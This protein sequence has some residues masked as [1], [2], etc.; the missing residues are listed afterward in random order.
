MIWNI[1][2]EESVSKGQRPLSSLAISLLESLFNPNL[3][4]FLESGSP[5]LDS[6]KN[7]LDCD[8]KHVDF[9]H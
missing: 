6:E 5:W 9:D 2:F 1:E 7:A 3:S 4:N 8:L